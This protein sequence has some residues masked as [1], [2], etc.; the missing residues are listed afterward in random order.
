M[1][2]IRT[3]AKNTS[4]L[5]GGEAVSRVLTFLITLY[6]ARSLGAESLGQYAFA[7][8]FVSLFRVFA[9]MGLN[10]LTTREVAK[11]HKMAGKYLTNLLTIKSL[12]GF[13]TF[14][15]VYLAV[16]ATGK[17]EELSLLVY[18]AALWIWAESLGG[19]VQSVFSGFES[20]E[21]VALLNVVE[22]A[23]L[24]VVSFYALLSDVPH[25]LLWLISAYPI[26]SLC[27]FFVGIILLALRGLP[28]R[29]EVDRKFWMDVLR[30]GWPFALMGIL[31][32]IYLYTDRVLLSIIQGEDR[33]VGWYTAGA[34]A[35]WTVHAVQAFFYRALFP[36]A[37]KTYSESTE[38]Y[39]RMLKR[40]GRFIFTYT[41]PVATVGIVWA[42]K[43]VDFFYGHNYAPTV[44][45]LQ[46]LLINLVI[47]GWTGLYGSTV[48]NVTG[49]QKDFMCAVG[50]GA[51]VNVVLN[52]LLIPPL[53]L[54][55][56]AVAT[57]CAEATVGLVAYL[58]ARKVVELSVAQYIWKPALASGAMAVLWLYGRGVIW[59]ASGFAAFLALLWLTRCVRRQDISF[60]SASLG[61]RRA[62]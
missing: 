15:L 39:I 7:L 42:P 29:M 44:L 43:V 18:V 48:L 27:A 9:D 37:S 53:S 34:K 46:I 57:V 52:I 24:F 59:T 41:I 2:T 32:G 8:A 25:K 38:D 16:H 40:T 31:G 49:R 12:L 61:L 22:K 1:N 30:A 54:N 17:S 13:L 3:V 23:V 62:A 47:K 33:V 45:V 56:V 26:S 6:I 55:G 28:V 35:F 60:L 19:L 21:Y 4:A 20:M 14:L 58:R 50:L 11:D 36:T 5:L 51:L 10:T